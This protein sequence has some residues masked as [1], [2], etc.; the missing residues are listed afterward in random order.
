[1]KYCIIITDGAADKPIESLGGK[2]PLQAARLPNIER[3]IKK[4]ELGQVHTVP[5]GYAPGSDVAI[6]SLLG[7]SPVKYYSGRAPIEAAAQGIPVAEG[8]WV[9][10]CNLV[11]LDKGLMKDHAADNIST[12]EATELM[13]A[14][15]EKLGRAGLTFYPGVSYR[16]LMICRQ[17]FNVKTT[18]PHDILDKPFGEYFP[19]GEGSDLL[20]KLITESRTILEAHPVNKKR[21][22]K[23]LAPANSIWF[24]GEGTSPAFDSFY[25]RFGLKGAVI[26]AVD[27]VRGIGGLMGWDILNVPGATGFIE[28]NFKGKGD[29]TIE[30]LKKYDI[31]CVH[32]EAPDEAGHAG[33]PAEKV[34]AMEEIDTHIAGPVLDYLESTGEDWRILIMPDH[35]TPCDMRTHTS[36]PVLYTMAGKGIAHNGL[37]LFTEDEAAGS[38]IFIEEGYTLVDRLLK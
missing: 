12:E 14:L 16:N 22:E 33:L 17:N 20:N 36:D 21:I 4:G 32:I 11:T 35:P 6:M 19:E 10:R 26:A 30:A 34:K 24:W 9:F 28:T 2:T 13:R 5:K 23:G 37:S 29:K 25:E 15:E 8:E 31:V 27:L 3:V 38:D 18:P 7:N 1:M